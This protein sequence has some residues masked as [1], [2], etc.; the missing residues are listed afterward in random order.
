MLANFQLRLWKKI[1]N[2]VLEFFKIFQVSF[3]LGLWYSPGYPH[4]VVTWPYIDQQYYL[5]LH[6]HLSMEDLELSTANCPGVF[7]NISISAFVRFW[8]SYGRA[9]NSLSICLAVEF[10]MIV[11][12]LSLMAVGIVDNF[13]QRLLITFP[14][15]S[16]STFSFF[17]QS[18]AK[19][20]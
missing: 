12:Y 11:L 15:S 14:V 4:R 13:K 5:T 7:F 1:V 9:L 3:K 8:S 16:F 2:L 19:R 17:L 20:S 6:Y 10:C 18:V